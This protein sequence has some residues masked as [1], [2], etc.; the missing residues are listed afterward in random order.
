M[1]K[2]K[3]LEGDHKLL[4]RRPVACH[5]HYNTFVDGA[6]SPRRLKSLSCPH[7]FVLLRLT[8]AVLKC[9]TH[10]FFL[11]NRIKIGLMYN[12]TRE[13]FTDGVLNFTVYTGVRH[14]GWQEDDL[15]RHV[16]FL[17][18]FA[19]VP[20]PFLFPDRSTAPAG[21]RSET[22]FFLQGL[23]STLHSDVPSYFPHPCRRPT[24]RTPADRTRDQ[25]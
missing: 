5:L 9:T 11:V 2:N 16:L 12:L 24:L 6:G 3:L 4:S 10:G 18:G 21:T 19:R 1:T 20:P 13:N 23:V 8:L 22:S 17:R 7:A 25:V 14:R 15:T